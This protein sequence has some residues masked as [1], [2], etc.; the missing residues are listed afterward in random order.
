MS[1]FVKIL[2]GWLIFDVIV[3]LLMWYDSKDHH[4]NIA[5]T[6]QNIKESFTQD[7]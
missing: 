3:Y 1:L 4:F 2:L 6:I 5:Q 7:E